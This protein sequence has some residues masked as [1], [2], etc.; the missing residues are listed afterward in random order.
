M[1]KMVLPSR[2]RFLLKYLDE[3]RALLILVNKWDQAQDI[4][5]VVRLKITLT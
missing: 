5:E 3:G 4:S 2:T 1:P